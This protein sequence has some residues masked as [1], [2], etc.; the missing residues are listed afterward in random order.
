MTTLQF[1][2]FFAAM[3]V[4]YVLLHL[5]LTRLEAQRR[6]AQRERLAAVGRLEQRL[7]SIHE[8]VERSSSAGLEK[9]LGQVA[10]EL[11]EDL[12]ELRQGARAVEQALAAQA[13]SARSAPPAESG[14][15]VRMPRSAEPST[16]GER[17]QAAIEARLLAL[18]YGDLRILGDLSEVRLDES[19]E[20][21]VECTR[22]HMPC[23]GTVTIRNGGVADVALQTAAQSFP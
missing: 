11:H 10:G 20:V 9:L 19:Y 17:V 6:D 23:K 21:R 1:S 16:A 12:A 22:Q 13:A 8:V 7:Q 3:L 5:R 18:G 4:A 14:P 2:L 15:A